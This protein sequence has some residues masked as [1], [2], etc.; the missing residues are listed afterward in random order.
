MLFDRIGKRPP[1]RRAHTLGTVIGVVALA[2]L[3]AAFATA[4][5][6]SR[7]S[8]PA[9]AQALVASAMKPKTTWI[10]PTSSPP[11]ATGKTIG[12]IPC[13]TFVEGCAREANGVIAAAKAVGWKTI[14]INGNVDPQTEQKAMDSLIARKVDAIVLNSI[15]ASSVGEGMAHA[16]SAHIPV[17][18]SFAQDPTKFGGIG[19]V[20]IDDTLAGEVIGAYM[21][22]QGGGNVVAVYDNSAQEVVERYEGLRAALKKFGGGKVIASDAISGSQIGPSES[23]LMSSLLQKY[24][25]GQINW[26]FCGYD[27]MCVPLIQEIQRSGRTEIKATGYDGNLQNLGFI[28]KGSVQVAAVGYPLEWAGWASIDDLN[29][30][31]NKATLWP[32]EK[33]F[34]FRLLTKTDVPKAG[35]SYQGDI[36]YM[37]KFKQLWKIK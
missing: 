20:R 2:L 11:L 34:D 5:A 8:A 22:T 33:Y 36:D 19:D 25:K 27:F 17:I 9:A 16:K 15:N 30:Y 14:E 4:S 23:G 7:K 21:L 10:G 6:A 32:G 26:V 35:S 3:T 13:A 29:R 12:V 1:S 24:P 28:R 31:F 18:V 37:A